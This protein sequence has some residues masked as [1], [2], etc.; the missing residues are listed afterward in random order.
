[1]ILMM[2]LMGIL[3][4]FKLTLLQVYKLMYETY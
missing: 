1:M 3:E 2:I 4:N